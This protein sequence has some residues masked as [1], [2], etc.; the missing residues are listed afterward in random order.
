MQER[1]G[2]VLYP[3]DDPQRLRPEDDAAALRVSGERRDLLCIE[4]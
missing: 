3:I 4:G 2:A 1:G